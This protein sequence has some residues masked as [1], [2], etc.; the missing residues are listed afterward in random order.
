[1]LCVANEPVVLSQ[2]KLEHRNSMANR[3]IV[4]T[5]THRQRENTA[6]NPTGSVTSYWNPLGITFFQPIITPVRNSQEFS[7]LVFG[8]PRDYSAILDI[9]RAL[10]KKGDVTRHHTMFPEFIRLD[11]P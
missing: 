10:P 4:D 8:Y 9:F 11:V 7:E 3:V 1:M 6:G 2:Y 5:G